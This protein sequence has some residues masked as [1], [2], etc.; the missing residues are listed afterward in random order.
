MLLV[1]K[2]SPAAQNRYIYF[3]KQL[4]KLPHSGA[5]IFS[6]L[7][8]PVLKG[9]VTSILT[10]PFRS[11]RPKDVEDESVES[12]L[13]RRIGP[14]LT[15]NLVS[16]VFHGIYAG[17]IAK[18][19]ADALLHEM[20]RN[21]R[22]YGGLLRGAFGVQEMP[23]DDL[24]L[25][26]M[27]AK[28]SAGLLNK[29]KGVSIYSFK[30]GM[31]T[32]TKA[33][34]EDA[35]ERENV[36]IRTGVEV[37]GVRYNEGKSAIKVL[38]YPENDNEFDFVISALPSWKTGALLPPD[39]SDSLFETTGVTVMVVNLFYDKPNVVGRSGFG[40]LI[41]KSVP[42]EQNP[43][44][45]LGVIF[46]SDAIPGQDERE[47]SKV[48]VMLGGHWWDEAM[49]HPSEADGIAMAK[50]VLYQHL[51]I[52]DAPVET[53]ANLHRDCIPQY[54]VGHAGRLRQIHEDLL[55]K[56]GGRLVLAG[57]S[58]GGVGLNDSVRSARDA[59]FGVAAG[60]K[61]TGLEGW[62]YEKQWVA[63]A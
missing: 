9:A 39:T 11:R 8:L 29:M 46:D 18:L 52:T 54:G 28:R 3:D 58:Y 38:G 30:G 14:D 55:E 41:P 7:R 53:R 1:P 27:Y 33:L 6:A 63:K 37:T 25:R 13:T 17:D 19:S 24:I 2:T 50:E 60:Q 31:E 51:G 43:H 36:T 23:V 16:A 56:M 34:A 40:Y 26:Q 4:N 48:T 35:R 42:I 45:A 10:E 44:R 62:A 12:F 20:Y 21:E 5:G 47:G 59:A 61:M 15:N 32:F 57:N 22:L 49:S